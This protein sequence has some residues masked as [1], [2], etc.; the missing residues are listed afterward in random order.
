MKAAVNTRWHT[1]YKTKKR[2]EWECPMKGAT[3][4]LPL[5]VSK[6]TCITGDKKLTD[7][8]KREFADALEAKIAEGNDIAVQFFNNN[9]LTKADWTAKDKDGKAKNKDKK[10]KDN[11]G[12]QEQVKGR[13]RGG[14]K[15][16]T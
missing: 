2:A 8:A 4:K 5:F 6:L 11:K 13:R 3:D 9:K 14:R 10:G 1:G 16:R 12:V 7:P 15:S